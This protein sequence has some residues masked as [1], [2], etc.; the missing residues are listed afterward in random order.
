MI[1]VKGMLTNVVDYFKAPGAIKAVV[2]LGVWLYTFFVHG[3]GITNVQET[4]L[5]ILTGLFGASHI[6]SV[7]ANRSIKVVTPTKPVVSQP[8]SS[9]W[10]TP[11]SA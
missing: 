5:S 11:P 3:T 10:T 4:G 2:L 7:S 8:T 9:P 6:Y 1:N